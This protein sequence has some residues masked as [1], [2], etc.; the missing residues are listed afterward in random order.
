MGDLSLERHLRIH[1][2]ASLQGFPP[3]IGHV[4]VTEK[5]GRRIFGNAMA[6]PVGSVL[7]VELR[8]IQ[9]A[10]AARQQPGGACMAG[11]AEDLQTAQRGHPGSIAP[12]TRAFRDTWFPPD[13]ELHVDFGHSSAEIAQ[14]MAICH[15]DSGSPGRVHKRQRPLEPADHMVLTRQTF[16]QTVHTDSQTSF[17]GGHTASASIKSA[18]AA[19]SS[20][21]WT[22]QCCASGPA[23]DPSSSGADIPPASILPSD[24]E[25][26]IM[27][28]RWPSK[29][30]R[31]EAS[32]DTGHSDQEAFF[33]SFA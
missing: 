1:E 20:V 10:R 11:S 26:P 31:G 6:V 29:E 23:L 30:A 19:T 18:S 12:A 21:V 7:A 33:V 14:E 9:E 17:A 5:V 28:G 25:E 16:S 24:E 2:R 32:S 4:K 27:P 22:P 15:S 13:E 3:T 8:C